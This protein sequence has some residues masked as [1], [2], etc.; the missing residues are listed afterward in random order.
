MTAV[1]LLVQFAFMDRDGT[2][3]GRAVARRYVHDLYRAIREAH[4]RPRRYR[5]PRWAC[6]AELGARLRRHLDDGGSTGDT[7]APRQVPPADGVFRGGRLGLAGDGGSRASAGAMFRC[8]SSMLMPAR[9]LNFNVMVYT[10]LLFGLLAFHRE[11]IWSQVLMLILAAG[12]LTCGSSMVWESSRRAPA[13]IAA[14]MLTLCGFS[15]C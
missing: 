7:T 13:T 12:L 15:I 14:M 9:L 5:S 1:S 4:R 8:G 3:C 6:S 2:A 10:A 11:E